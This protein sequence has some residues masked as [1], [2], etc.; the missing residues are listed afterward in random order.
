MHGRDYGSQVIGIP[1]EQAVRAVLGQQISVRAARNL[2]SRL[3]ER[4]G[5]TV[6]F[7]EV[8]ELRFAFPTPAQLAHA[9][10]AALGMPRHRAA[11]LTTLAR[12]VEA[13]PDFLEAGPNL[14]NVLQRLKALPGFGD[15]TA[16]YIAMRALREPDAFPAGDVALQRALTHDDGTRPTAAQLLS[17]AEPWRPW[18]AYAAQYLWVT[19]R[20]K[21]PV[22][23][24][25]TGG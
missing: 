13:D 9:D 14:D 10:I 6:Q 7:G 21:K 19:E 23:R 4:W 11:A 20:T 15:W 5:D 18:R 16:N 25:T 12:A 8:E 2:A 17:R 3:V 22:Q 1:F 24:A